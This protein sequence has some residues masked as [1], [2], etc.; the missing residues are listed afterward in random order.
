MAFIAIYVINKIEQ[1]VRKT[2]IILLVMSLFTENVFSQSLIGIGGLKFLPGNVVMEDGSI[3]S[4]LIQI[5]KRPSSQKIKFK[6]S[7]KAAEQTVKIHDVKS[8]SVTS[9][10]GEKHILESNYIDQS[11]KA[12]VKRI[13]KFR[14]F[15]LVDTKGHANLYK[16]G[17]EFRT[18]KNGTLYLYSYNA[19]DGS[20]VANFRYYIKKQGSD[21]AEI[22]E[23]ENPK[24]GI[25]PDISRRSLVKSMEVHLSEY[26]ELIDKIKNKKI[27]E[28]DLTD[29]FDQYN[30][31]MAR[32]K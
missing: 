15:L 5:P 2:V 16:V 32:K 30:N 3:K 28:M 20:G 7:E 18:D 1:R 29:I 4:G 12:G 17:D 9:D 13:T 21:Y 31:F 10:L 26:P 22:F 27:D 23:Y 14:I 8:F 11:K 25:L 24:N 19:G 6:D